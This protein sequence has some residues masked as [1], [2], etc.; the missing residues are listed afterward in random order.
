MKDGHY[1]S[2]RCSSSLTSA[3]LATL[4]IKAEKA[5]WIKT[6]VG[7]VCAKCVAKKKDG[8]GA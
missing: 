6:A 7:D 4:E 8:L 3:S 2:Y 1:N 5:G